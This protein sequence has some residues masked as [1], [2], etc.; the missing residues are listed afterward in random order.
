[1]SSNIPKSSG[2]Y[3]IT[4]TATG[5]IYI[6][7]SINLHKRW[8]EHCGGLRRG[9]HGNQ[10][11][12]R[13]WDKYGAQSFIFEVLELVLIPEFLTAREQYWIDKLKPFGD[14]GFNMAPTAGSTLGRKFSPETKKKIADAQRG[15]KESPETRAKLSAMRKGQPMPWLV[16][17]KQSPETREKNRIAQLGNTRRLGIK[18]TAETRAKMSANSTIKGK[19]AHNRGSKHTPEAI[20]KIRLANIGRVKSAETRAKQSASVKAAKASSRKTIIVTDPDGTVYTVTGIRQFC[21]DHNLDRSTLMRV[22][23]GIHSHHKGW[24]ARFPESDIS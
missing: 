11:L 5:K 19:P 18:H 6:G 10:K 2:I 24:K 9:D 21:E 14:N 12:Q 20:E 15:K 17:R 3:R 23:K 13:A 7:S 8:L 22:A 16:G 4:C 1:M